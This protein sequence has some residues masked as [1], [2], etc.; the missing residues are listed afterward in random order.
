MTGVHLPTSFVWPARFR[1][2]AAGLPWGRPPSRR[3]VG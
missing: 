1:D 2:E 3:V